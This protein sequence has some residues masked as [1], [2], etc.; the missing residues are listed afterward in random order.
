VCVRAFT[1]L[2]R[3]TFLLYTVYQETCHCIFDYNLYKNCPIATI[4]GAIIT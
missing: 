2:L 1:F 3:P 4:F